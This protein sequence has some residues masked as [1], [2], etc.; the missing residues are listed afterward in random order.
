[1]IIVLPLDVTSV[2]GKVVWLWGE[3]R[4]LRNHDIET[5]CQAKRV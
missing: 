1:M 5:V 2:T 3:V 4:M